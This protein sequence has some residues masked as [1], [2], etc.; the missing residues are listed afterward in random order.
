MNNEAMTFAD[1]VSVNQ[2]VLIRQAAR[3]V[4]V[5]PE[6]ACW[7]FAGCYTQDLS[8]KAADELIDYLNSLETQVA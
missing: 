3:R 4:N 1:L 7:E 5:D 2:L 6:Q 8:K